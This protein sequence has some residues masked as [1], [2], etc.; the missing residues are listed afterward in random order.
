MARSWPLWRT[1][2]GRLESISKTA[3]AH[4]FS[5]I[6]H[7]FVGADETALQKFSG[8][9]TDLLVDITNVGASAPR[10]GVAGDSSSPLCGHGR[11]RRRWL[12]ARITVPSALRTLASG[13]TTPSS[14]ARRLCTSSTCQRLVFWTTSSAG[15]R[16]A[17]LG[18]S[19][20]SSWSTAPVTD[21]AHTPSLVSSSGRSASSRPAAAVCSRPSRGWR[22]PGSSAFGK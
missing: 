11:I 8:I 22:R 5:H 21:L 3:D 17:R 14:S 19:R 7:A 9:I 2:S 6:M 12:A 15:R 1:R 4:I 18:R 20:P 10:G 13:R 16:G